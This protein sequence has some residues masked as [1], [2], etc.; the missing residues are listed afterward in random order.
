MR[1]KSIL[2]NYSR[3]Y[4]H[5]RRAYRAVRHDTPQPI[6][7]VND[8][9]VRVIRP[10]DAAPLLLP[11]EY[12]DLVTAVGRAAAAALD[13]TENCQLIPAPR[14]PALP[15]LTAD[16]PEVGDGKVIT[17]KLLDP[18]TIPHVQD[19]C[20]P[21]LRQ[22]EEKIYRSFAIVDKVYVYRSPVCRGAPI[23]SWL[24]HFDNHPRELLKVMIYL[25]EVTDDS[26]PFEYLRDQGGRPV[27]GGP[28]APTFGNSRVP[29]ATVQRHLNLGG[30]IER[31]TGPRGTLIVF[32]DNV[33][34]R[35]T[36]ARASP[37]DVLV[38]QVRPAAF[39][40]RSHIDPR[41]TGSFPH[42]AFNTD[43]ADLTPHPTEGALR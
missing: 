31:V 10:G 41:W 38:F 40:P 7:T 33:I 20:E 25:T 28:L 42:R 22:L 30:S 29:E 43:P 18:F 26:A 34:H 37:R 35:A 24:W 9:G 4:Q 13:R 15:A 2:Y 11:P 19:V 1:G 21:L 32:D 3:H 6:C 16:V 17:I 5:S 23:A 27:Y 14:T 36:L 12:G 8:V 39:A